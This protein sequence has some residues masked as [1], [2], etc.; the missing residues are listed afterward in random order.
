[1]HDIHF[2]NKR[3]ICTKKGVINRNTCHVKTTQQGGLVYMY[4]F[5][6]R[7]ISWKLR[8]W[9]STPTGVLFPTENTVPW[10]PRQ[11]PCLYSSD[12]MTSHDITESHG[13]MINVL[14]LVRIDLAQLLAQVCVNWAIR[15]DLGALKRQ[16]LKQSIS[17]GGRKMMCFLST[18]A[19]KHI[20]V[21]TKKKTMNLI[22]SLL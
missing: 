14:Q 4:I 18:K 5:M 7:L 8:R 19:C 11:Q 20:L 9:K 10:M 2:T 1:M 21:I 22:M 6:Y 16:E 3:S 12:F 17:D 15:A 13:C